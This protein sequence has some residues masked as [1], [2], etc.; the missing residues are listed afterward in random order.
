M[1]VLKL[2]PM[3]IQS[4]EDAYRRGRGLL[5]Q[6]SD[7]LGDLVLLGGADLFEEKINLKIRKIRFRSR[8][9]RALESG[10]KYFMTGGSSY[11]LRFPNQLLFGKIL[12]N[13]QI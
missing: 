12:L 6:H 3:L 13:V 8:G 1:N 5:G 10:L 11:A 4:Y 7:D 9:L 2:L